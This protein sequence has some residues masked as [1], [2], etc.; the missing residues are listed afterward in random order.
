MKT[1]RNTRALPLPPATL[2]T[3]AALVLCFSGLPSAAQTITEINPSQS[4]LY[5]SDPDGAS[6]GRVNHVGV[7]PTDKNIIFAAS[8]WGGIYK[9]TDRGQTWAHLNDHHPTVTWDV[10]VSPSDDKRVIATSFYDGRVKSRAGINLSTDGGA[11]WTHPASAT[12]PAGFCDATRRDEPAAFGISFDPQTP[13]DVYV[14]TNCGLAISHDGGNTWQFVDPTPNDPADDVWSVAVHHNGIIDLCGDDGHRRSTNGGTSW[15][16]ASGGGTPLNSGRCS[17][18]ASPDES[19]VLFAVVGTTI[20]ESDNGGQSWTSGAYTNPK[21][22]GRIPF[23]KTNSRGSP[24]YD[25]WFGDVSVFRGKCTTPSPAAP[26]GSL[27]CQASTSWAGGFTRSNGSHD[28]MGDVAFDPAPGN[29]PDTQCQQDCDKQRD[30]CMSQVGK[31][32][33]PLA[34][35]CVQELKVCLNQCKPVQGKPLDACPMI[36]SSDG[37]VFPNK[38]ATTPS[39]QTPQWD[40]PKVTPHGLW[41]F[42]MNSVHAASGDNESLYFGVQ[43]DGTF[44]APNAQT[45]SPLWSNRDCCDSFDMA[46]DTNQVVYT[47]CCFSPRATRLF[48]RHSGMTGGAEIGNYPAGDIMGWITPDQVD[49]FGGNEYVLLTDTG[50]FITK[51]IT[52]SPIVW[53][54]LGSRPNGACGVRASVKSGK[55]SFFVQAGSC[56]TAGTDRIWR[57]DG[58]AT[59]GT[60]QQIDPPKS[61]AGFGIFTVDRSNPERMFAS[62]I[63]GASVEMVISTNGGST[64]SKLSTLDTAMT[65]GGTYNYSNSSGPTDFTEFNGYVQ[66]TVVG[67]S[68]FNNKVLVAAGADSGVFL[69]SDTGATWTTVTDNSGGGGN[70]HVPRAKFASFDRGGGNF[71]IYLGTQGRGVWRLDYPDP[72]GAC[73][74]KCANQDKACGQG[75]DKDRDSCMQ[76]IPHNPQLCVQELKACLNLCAKDYA[77]CKSQCP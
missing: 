21:P 7:A 41:A 54:A 4:T 24:N 35:D 5:S 61:F 56:D 33:G 9:S 66:P 12:P 42:G 48:L 15:T 75:C 52:A 77:T 8:E 40:Q 1:A 18:A 38:S 46:V 59:G 49:R 13:K 44:A 74:E 55:P 23:V 14:G 69:S 71:T 32:G 47:V 76:Q 64:W 72:S 45:N 17:I 67:F 43:D 65:G 31:P 10:K 63:S 50:A 3:M 51:D 62:A 70:P 29:A 27:R 39:C 19:Y 20:F 25:L 11:T 30:Q 37:G 73:Q 57:Y 2:M 60:W 58:T 53:S 16:S 36:M 34:K 22:Q 26:G 68:P 28:D 6:G